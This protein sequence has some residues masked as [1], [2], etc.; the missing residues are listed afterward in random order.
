MG[1]YNAHKG[2]SWCSKALVHIWWVNEWIGLGL[3]TIWLKTTKDFSSED[4]YEQNY[5]CWK[6]IVFNKNGLEENE[7]KSVIHWEA[8]EIIQA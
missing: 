6:I 4:T 5:F 3:N 8:T 1:K 7:T 2:L